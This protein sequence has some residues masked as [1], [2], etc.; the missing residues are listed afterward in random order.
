MSKLCF[1]LPKVGISLAI[2][3]FLWAFSYAD[4][5]E[6]QAYIKA[7]FHVDQDA[8]NFER[9]VFTFFLII[10]I[11]YVI[12]SFFY[13]FRALSTSRLGITRFKKQAGALVL[14]VSGCTASLVVFPFES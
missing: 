8:R 12:L 1:Y 13:S 4:V 10:M 7:D 2:F 9:S 5:L 11:A 14:I 3:V 6:Y